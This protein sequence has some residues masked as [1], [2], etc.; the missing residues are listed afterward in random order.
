MQAARCFAALRLDGQDSAEERCVLVRG[1]PFPRMRPQGAFGGTG[2]KLPFGKCIVF[3][4]RLVCGSLAIARWA[5]ARRFGCF[6]LCRLALS[7]R[8]SVDLLF[9]SQYLSP[10]GTVPSVGRS[11]KPYA[12]Q[13]HLK[14]TV[15]MLRLL[16]HYAPLRFY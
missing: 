12:V 8:Y 6:P 16:Q 1:A 11:A 5:D 2:I 14:T 15:F 7:R 4:N 13:D 10:A 3:S 9:G